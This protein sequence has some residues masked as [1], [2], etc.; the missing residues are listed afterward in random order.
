[1]TT[2]TKF[3]SGTPVALFQANPR[4]QVSLNDVFVYDVRRDGQEFLINT[5]SGRQRLHQCPSF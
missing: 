4:E 5:K 3:D 1:V 2:G